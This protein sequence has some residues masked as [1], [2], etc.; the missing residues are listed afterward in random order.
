MI[1]ALFAGLNSSQTTHLFLC[2]IN[3]SCYYFYI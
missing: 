1:I 2:S 3:R